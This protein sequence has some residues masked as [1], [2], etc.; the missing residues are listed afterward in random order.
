MLYWLYDLPVWTMVALI[1]LVFLLFTWVGAIFVRPFLKVFVWRQAG[2]NE[3]L[4]YLLGAHGVYFG[5]L[6]GLLAL[7]AYE[8]FSEVDGLIS[9]EATKTGVVY[10]GVASY[11]EPTRTELM[12]S[13]RAYVRFLID[14][15]WPE[16]RRGRIHPRGSVLTTEFQQV[17]MAFEPQTRSQEILHAE[18]LRQFNDLVELRRE[19]LNAVTTGIP[20]ILWFVVVIGI[21]VNI[22]LIWLLDMKLIAHLFLGGLIAFFLGTMIA[23]IAAMDNPFRGE[24]SVQPTAFEMVWTSLMSKD[25]AVPSARSPQTV[26]A[27]GR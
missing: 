15:A 13:M 10:R 3:V 19:R 11:P 24:E 9:R 26:P 2:L 20:P 7:A 4:G 21:V 12:R 16:Q 14:E 17:L 22:A 1:N 8:N 23:L 27:T 25:L 18:T 6:L 5:I